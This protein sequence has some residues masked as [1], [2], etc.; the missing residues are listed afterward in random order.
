MQPGPEA[1][2]LA[3]LLLS[4]SGCWVSSQHGDII[5]QRL[6]AL[7]ADS[8]DQRKAIADQERRLLAK[9]EQT[10]AALDRL[11]SGT[12][13]SGADLD[14]RLDDLTE[15]LHELQGEL[16][17]ALHH[18]QGL[19]A[20]QKANSTEVDQKLAAALGSQ[21]LAQVDA[22]EKAMKLAPPDRA[23]LFAVAF[24]QYGAGAYEV[25]GQLFQEYLR[26]YPKDAK[27]GDA[28][29]F[30]AE[31]SFHAGQ[32]KQAALGYQKVVDAYGRSDKVCDARL[33]LGAS[34]AALKMRP[35][36]KLAYQETLRRCGG[37]IAVARQARHALAALGSHRS[38]KHRRR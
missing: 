15:K 2:L 5:D 17:E 12:H 16:S 33:G 25:A 19:A 36:A 3:P 8:Q 22:R 14:A 23:G 21:A 4:L 20:A 6:Q 18:L 32:Y 1:R 13:R 35:E 27:D 9:I 29:F 24:Q 26:R 30:V 28:Q 7:E 11:N 31:S 38:A 37:K 34:L 10:R